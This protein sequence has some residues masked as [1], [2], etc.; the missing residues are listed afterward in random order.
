MKVS[1]IRDLFHLE[2][3]SLSKKILVII[4]DE[5]F[6]D[7]S[8]LPNFLNYHGN[9]RFDNLDNFEGLQV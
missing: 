1:V 5:R 9:F 2:K 3:G 7:L 4:R 8:E 6:T